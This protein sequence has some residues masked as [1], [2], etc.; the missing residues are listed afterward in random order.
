MPPAPAGKPPYLVMIPGSASSPHLGTRQSPLLPLIRTLD[1][2]LVALLVASCGLG[3]SGALWRENFQNGQKAYLAGNVTQAEKLLSL[4]L[5]QADRERISGAQRAEICETLGQ[6]MLEQHN[7]QSAESL[8]QQAVSL[9]QESG[10]G[11]ELL[12]DRWGLARACLF[13]GKYAQAEPV[14][15]KIEQQ[16]QDLTGKPLSEI[17]TWVGEYGQ[18]ERICKNGLAAS[19]QATPRDDLETAGWL[20]ALAIVHARQERFKLSEPLWKQALSIYEQHGRPPGLASAKIMTNLGAALANQGRT[21]ES[22]ALLLA[23][24]QIAQQDLPSARGMLAVTLNNLADLYARVQ[25]RHLARPLYKRSLALLEQAGLSRHP[26]YACVAGNLGLLYQS[27]GLEEDGQALR[28]LAQ[29]ILG[30]CFGTG[31]K[32]VAEIQRSAC[33]DIFLYTWPA[34]TDWRQDQAATSGR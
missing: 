28:Q 16:R 7:W 25:M 17:Y 21:R 5:A 9:R 32:P 22:E 30:A 15:A 13:Q 19:K 1:A 3:G 34:A 31:S 6:L 23:A 20:N 12:Q 29:N 11:L 24:R 26:E 2:A 10:G 18:A 14:L 8:F 33:L 4:S 27:E